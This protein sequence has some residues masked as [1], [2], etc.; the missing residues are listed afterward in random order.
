VRRGI[1]SI[2][3]KPQRIELK[4]ESGNKLIG[5]STVVLP[6]S[7]LSNWGSSAKHR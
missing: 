6:A 1:L 3:S 4:P 5:T 2:A 7:L